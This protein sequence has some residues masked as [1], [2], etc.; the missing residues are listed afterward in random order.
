MKF[1]WII[2]RDLRIQILELMEEL[3]EISLGLR[4]IEGC[5][6]YAKKTNDVQI[7]LGR[8]IGVLMTPE[9]NFEGKEHDQV[10]STTGSSGSHQK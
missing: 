9:L 10:R 2:L 1:S 5:N 6:H 3:Q 7:R 4:E 8:L